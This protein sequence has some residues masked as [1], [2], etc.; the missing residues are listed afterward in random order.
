MGGGENWREGIL[1]SGKEGLDGGMGR[2]E[3]GKRNRSIGNAKIGPRVMVVVQLI[4]TLAIKKTY[5]YGE[6]VSQP[7]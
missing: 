1:R 4:H 6:H 7:L 5:Q 3:S 2:R